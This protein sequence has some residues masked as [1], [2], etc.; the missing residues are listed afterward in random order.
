MFP[1]GQQ[2]ID[3][4]ILADP[5][6]QRLVGLDMPE[7]GGVNSLAQTL[8]LQSCLLELLL[9]GVEIPLQERK[10]E[11]QGLSPDEGGIEFVGASLLLV[12]EMQEMGDIVAVVHSFVAGVAAVL[13]ARPER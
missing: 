11:G 7:D 1:D 6:H 8:Q 13:S 10:A 12:G 2:Q 5:I 4:Q 9:V 3:I